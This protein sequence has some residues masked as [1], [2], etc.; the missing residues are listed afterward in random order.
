[1]RE[2]QRKSAFFMLFFSWAVRVES[3]CSQGC[4]RALASYLIWGEDLTF[5]SKLFGTPEKDILSVNNITNKDFLQN[6]TRINIPFSCN[7]IQGQ[8]L[9]HN[10]SYQVKSGDTYTLVQ[11]NYSNLV[12]VE[13]LKSTNSYREFDIPDVD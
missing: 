12:S 8:Y 6:G 4:D 13:W 7:W 5:I 10:F 3:K 11:N 1:M 2:L 9:G